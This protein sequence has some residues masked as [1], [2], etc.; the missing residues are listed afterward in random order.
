[1]PPHFLEL[2]VEDIVVGD[3]PQLVLMERI[4]LQSPIR[5]RGNYQMD[6]FDSDPVEMTRIALV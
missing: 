5:R 2:V 6:G 1:M 3:E 4:F